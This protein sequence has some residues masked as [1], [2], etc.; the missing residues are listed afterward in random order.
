L[1][2][3]FG[4][5]TFDAAR[6]QLLRGRE[7]VHHT[8]KAFQLLAALLE[9][10]PRALS[11]DELMDL[12]WPESLVTEATLSSLVSELRGALGDAARK[13]RHLRTVH[14]FGYA[15]AG[16]DAPAPAADAPGVAVHRLL[17]G[18][19]E[20]DLADGETVVGRERLARVWIADASISRRHARIVV[21]GE[22]AVLEDLGSK[23]GT[24]RGTERLE[25]T[26][27]VPLADGDELRFGSVT[28]TYRNLLLGASTVTKVGSRVR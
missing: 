13:P 18:S 6:R 5:F 4:D 2:L 16:A 15:F 17:W 7:P 20:I 12:L 24:Y 21:S 19:R 11:K 1:A 22:S 25:S 8:P 9:A 14:G 10:R 3:R 27:G 23:N 28:V 26:R